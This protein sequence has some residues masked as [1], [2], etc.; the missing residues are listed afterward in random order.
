MNSSTYR[1]R[2]SPAQPAKEVRRRRQ[3]MTGDNHH[4]SPFDKESQFSHSYGIIRDRLRGRMSGVPSSR[5][6]IFFSSC[7][8]YRRPSQRS[9]DHYSFHFP[10]SGRTNT[11]EA[12]KPLRTTGGDLGKCFFYAM[13]HR[14]SGYMRPPGEH[15]R[16]PSG[17]RL[18]TSCA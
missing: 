7:T 6:A 3:G 9:L 13:M 5:H 16:Y 14:S 11:I 10:S 15:R 2:M 18:P 1:Y 8:D 12:A 17:N 4:S